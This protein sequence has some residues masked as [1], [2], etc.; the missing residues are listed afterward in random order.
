MENEDT[1]ETSNTKVTQYPE[2]EEK[3]PQN[4]SIVIPDV[5]FSHEEIDAM[6]E[7]VLSTGFNDEEVITLDDLALALRIWKA[8]NVDISTLRVEFVG[9]NTELE[10]YRRVEVQVSNQD[11]DT[12]L[13]YKIMGFP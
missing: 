3:E 2:E 6:Y 7:N 12:Y 4:M 11:R 8:N 1:S 13:R 5:L 9:W 10:G